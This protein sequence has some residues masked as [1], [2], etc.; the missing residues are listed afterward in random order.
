L[1]ELAKLLFKIRSYTPIPFVVVMLIFYNGNL[2]SWLIGSA[3]LIL[4]ELIRLWGVSHAGSLTRTTTTVK[5]K[6]LVTSGPF[7]HVRNPLY[8]GNILMYVG[9]G[10]ISL[11]LFPYLP[12]F[13]LVWF[14]FQYTLIISIEEEFLESKFGS[15][16]VEYKDQVPRFLPRFTAMKSDDPQVIKPNLRKGLKSET[17]TIQAFSLV[18]VITFI[19]HLVK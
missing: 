3:V 16:Y 15:Q 9:F 11:A 5:A 17:R 10:I 13:A 18:A 1:K 12:I 14:V 2:I 19:I 7:A 4:G 6:Q 8:I